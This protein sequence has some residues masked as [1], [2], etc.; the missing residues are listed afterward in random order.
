MKFKDFLNEKKTSADKSTLELAKKLGKK[1]FENKKK[2]IPAQDKELIN[3]LSKVS[4][5]KEDRIK[6]LEI[7]TSIMKAW[8]KAW[9]MENLK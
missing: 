4:N 6:Q 9:D 8:L 5:P 7:S 1:A 2:R 3:L